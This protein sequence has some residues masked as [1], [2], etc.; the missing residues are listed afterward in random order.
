MKSQN[1]SAVSHYSRPIL[2]AARVAA[3]GSLLMSLVVESSAGLLMNASGDSPCAQLPQ[4]TIAIGSAS[5]PANCSHDES[6]GRI[7]SVSE[8]AG[9][10]V[11]AVLKTPSLGHAQLEAAVGVVQFALAPFAAGY[12][13]IKGSH[14]KLTPEEMGEVEDN[15]EQ[16]L[17]EMAQQDHLRQCVFECATEKSARHVVELGL[18]GKTRDETISGLLETRV[19]R[20]QLKRKGNHSQ[21]Y[22]LTITARARLLEGAGGKVVAEIPYSYTSGEA[23]FID[24]ARAGGLESAARTG[25]RVLGEQ[26]A[27]DFFAPRQEAPILLGAGYRNSPTPRAKPVLLAR[28]QA[29]TPPAEQFVSYHVTENG[30]FEILPELDRPEVLIRGPKTGVETTSE[31]QT[32]AEWKLDGLVNNRNFVVQAAACI[33]AVPL[34]L[35][36]QTVGAIG[37]WSERD[38]SEAETELRHITRRGPVQQE[39]ANEI[40]RQ[41]APRTSQAV[42]LRALPSTAEEEISGSAL[43]ISAMDRTLGESP[44][45]LQAATSLAIRLV[46]V[47]L[48]GKRTA[49]HRASLSLQAQVTL[50]RTGDGQE[51]CVWPVHYC[52]APRRL[53]EWSA[54]DGVLLQQE[55]RQYSSQVASAMVAQLLANGLV[56]P[57]PIIGPAMARN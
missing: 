32:D 35:W 29:A 24:W 1:S 30:A 13:V 55:L 9:D 20:L 4:G 31:T 44:G 17:G 3:V 45:H 53:K 26:I 51:L 37:R 15:L 21:N 12:G 57:Q 47:E 34:G 27:Q 54:P 28:R 46:K 52:S 14:R 10:A 50:R 39:L 25:Y 18:P 8:A 48:T 38:L 42:V 5:E 6:S 41:L 56:A 33:A 11:E 49:G 2:F 19:E 40:A 16:A 7:E 36:E 43:G 23:M 22:Q